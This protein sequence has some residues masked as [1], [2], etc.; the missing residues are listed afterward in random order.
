MSRIV[1]TDDL[2]D[3]IRKRSSVEVETVDDDELLDIVNSGL[4]ALHDVIVENGEDFLVETE[5]VD[6]VADQAEYSL[7]ADFYRLRGLDILSTSSDYIEVPKVD[8]RERSQFTES[9]SGRGDIGF[10]LQNGKVRL[11]PTPNF[12]LTDGLQV[13][14]TPAY[15]PAVAGG[16]IEGYN[17]WEEFVRN[18]ALAEL[19]TFMARESDI[20]ER[21]IAAHSARIGFAVQKQDRSGPSRMFNPQ[22]Q[23]GR[24]RYPR[25]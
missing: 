24:A 1:A 8:F 14:Y 16:N 23:R 19:A 13:W 17:G 9:T 11:M 20:Y 10:I 21:R 2:L 22:R 5:K 18:F 12:D 6:I 7:H 3:Q 15:T 4:A 25:P